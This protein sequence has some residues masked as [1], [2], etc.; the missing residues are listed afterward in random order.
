VRNLT[1][2]WYARADVLVKAKNR[3]GPAVKGGLGL[4]DLIWVQ[5]GG[6]SVRGS[7]LCDRFDVQT[8]ASIENPEDGGEKWV[9]NSKSAKDTLN[10]FNI[11][12]D[13]SVHCGEHNYYLLCIHKYRDSMIIRKAGSLCAIHGPSRS[14]ACSRANTIL[15]LYRYSYT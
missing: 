8:L 12:D 11:L 10:M 2:R 3:C 6:S 7:S 1:K 5:I 9:N 14:N 13:V 4:S 15:Y